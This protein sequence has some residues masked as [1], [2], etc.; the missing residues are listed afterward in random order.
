MIKIPTIKIKSKMQ[1][2]F[3]KKNIAQGG[4]INPCS[5]ILKVT[6]NVVIKRPQILMLNQLVTKT[7]KKRGKINFD[8]VSFIPYTKKSIGI[9]M[10]KG[11]GGT[12]GWSCCLKRGTTLI[13]VES[14]YNRL[15]NRKLLKKFSA[16]MPC[17]TLKITCNI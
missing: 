6:E 14:S 1:R 10:G 9:R 13:K 17:S 11:K 8:N 15:L 12:A 4:F 3:I 5:F 16:I 2:S 7:I